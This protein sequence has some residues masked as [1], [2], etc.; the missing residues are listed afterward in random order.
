[1]FSPEVFEKGILKCK[2]NIKVFEDAIQKE[3]DTIKEYRNMMAKA[4]EM[5][6]VNEESKIRIELDGD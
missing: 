3:M 2:D 1:M 5:D 4:E 6:R